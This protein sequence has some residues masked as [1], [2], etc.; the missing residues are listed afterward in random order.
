MEEL[1]KKRRRL[2]AVLRRYRRL[3][4]GGGLQAGLQRQRGHRQQPGVGVVRPGGLRDGGGSWES[5]DTGRKETGGTR[6][7]IEYPREQ[8]AGD[9][10]F[11]RAFSKSEADSTHSSNSP[12]ASTLLMRESG[13]KVISIA[14]DTA[15][16]A[17]CH[18]SFSDRVSRFFSG[19]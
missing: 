16:S 9:S 4:P 19:E 17:Y 5:L 10:V 8:F 18:V 14:K 13:S 15:C 3:G 11:E 6:A 12:W 7:S 2:S 1:L